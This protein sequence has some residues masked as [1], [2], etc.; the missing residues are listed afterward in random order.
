LF[1]DHAGR[2]FFFIGL[3]AVIFSFFGH[4]RSFDFFLCCFVFGSI[5][6]FDFRLSVLE[7]LSRPGACTPT[8]AVCR[9]GPAALPISPLFLI[10]S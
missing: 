1:L 2:F 3:L 10:A 7:R 8:L 5:L 6:A 4:E 9:P